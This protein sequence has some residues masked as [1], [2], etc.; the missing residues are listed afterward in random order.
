MLVVS[1]AYVSWCTGLVGKAVETYCVSLADCRGD[2]TIGTVLFLFFQRRR[3]GSFGSSVEGGEGCHIHGEDFRSS[4]RF[5]VLC[6][7]WVIFTLLAP[8]RL[9]RIVRVSVCFPREAEQSLMRVMKCIAVFLTLL[10]CAHAAVMAVDLGGQ[11][12]KVLS[13]VPNSHALDAIE[14]DRGAEDPY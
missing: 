10:G 2:R 13:P 5:C 11:F 6:F 8:K 9:L 14:A 1:S 7:V 3:G 12:F 4:V